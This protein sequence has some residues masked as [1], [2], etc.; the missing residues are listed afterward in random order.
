MN[1]KRKYYKG[2]CKKCSEHRKFVLKN[3]DSKGNL[4]NIRCTAC[5]NLFSI[6]IERV[7]KTGRVLTETEF[8][9][10]KEA[11]AKVTDY[12]PKKTYWRG[13]KIRHPALKDTGKVVDKTKSQGNHKI[14]IVKFEKQGKKR[15]VEAI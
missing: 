9:H 13:Q 3:Y 4:L 5:L 14:I 2:H 11:L 1:F 12:D 8:I 6:P 15:L 10:R 7:L